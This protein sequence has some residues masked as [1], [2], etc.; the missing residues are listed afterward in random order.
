MTVIVQEV[1][2]VHAQ[3]DQLDVLYTALERFWVAVDARVLHPPDTL[4]RLKFAI[5]VSEIGTNI[6]K[7]A[8]GAGNVQGEISLRLRLSYNTVEARFTD[9]GAAFCGVIEGSSP[10]DTGEPFPAQID[11]LSLPESGY[12]LALARG[13][14]DSISYRRSCGGINC[15]RLRKCLLA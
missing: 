1:I 2:V 15:W 8:Y 10:L 3:L 9:Q 6:M 13:F 14:V 7:H 4:W 11:I 5:A 12:G